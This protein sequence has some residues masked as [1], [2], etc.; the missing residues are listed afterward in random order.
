[1][2]A[3]HKGQDAAGCD[4]EQVWQRYVSKKYGNGRGGGGGVFPRQGANDLDVAFF[5]SLFLAPLPLSPLVCPRHSSLKDEANLVLVPIGPGRI[6]PRL[7]TFHERCAQQRVDEPVI[8]KVSIRTFSPV[9]PL[10]HSLYPR[11]SP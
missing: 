3:V 6:R 5:S 8:R 2:T 7:R 11:L 1:M 4:G 9:L 10:S